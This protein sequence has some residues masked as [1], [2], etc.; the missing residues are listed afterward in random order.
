MKSLPIV[1]LANYVPEPPPV[2]PPL[3][4]S[5]LARYEHFFPQTRA[6]ARQRCN[7]WAEQLQSAARSW[8]HDSDMFRSYLHG[9]RLAGFRL[10]YMELLQ[11]PKK[12]LTFEN[13]RP[14]WKGFLERKLTD[15]ELTALDNWKP[16]PA[17]LFEQIHA[18][19]EDEYDISLS[20]S[21]KTKLSTC[22]LKDIKHGRDTAGYALSS[23]DSDGASALKMAV[24][25]HVACMEK[26]WGT[27]LGQP[28]PR[29]R[30]G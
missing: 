6:E 5:H 4:H 26:K 19:L 15:E 8:Y 16:K 27:L 24:Y 9:T 28:P 17:E 14:E 13:Q 18:I 11:M 29:G 23:A 10:A 21:Q 2:P 22:T 30:R 7:R 12:N 1:L 25:K 3:I 20:Y